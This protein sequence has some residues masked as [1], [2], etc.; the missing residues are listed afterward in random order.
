MGPRAGLDGCGKSRPHQDSIAE[1]SS[2]YRVAIRTALSC[3]LFTV[4]VANKEIPSAP[5]QVSVAK[6]RRFWTTYRSYRQGSRI[7]EF[8]TIE[9]GQVAPK[10][11]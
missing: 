4:V 6:Y 11:R 3:S 7:Q 5:F 10:R 9:D 8:V 1:P 2:P